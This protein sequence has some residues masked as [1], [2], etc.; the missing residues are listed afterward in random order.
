[1]TLEVRMKTHAA[2]ALTIAHFLEK[3]AYVDE[4]IYPGLASH[5]QHDL[6][7]RQQRG[8]GGMLSFR[9]K[10]SLANVNA[11]LG[12]LRYIT[13]AESLG[14]VESLIEVP[15]VMTHGSISPEDRAK[16][17]I[18]DTLVRFSVGIE[19]V[20]DLVEDLRQALEYA[21]FEEVRN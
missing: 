12:R 4:V 3:H 21:Y 16:L 14:G 13:L 11:F 15:A 19:S 7:Q 5:P 18:T 9:M 6:A 1:M 10:G 2:N 20:E 17:G 8:F